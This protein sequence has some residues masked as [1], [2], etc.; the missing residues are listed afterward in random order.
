M[1]DLSLL[2]KKFASISGL[3]FKEGAGGLGLIEISTPICDAT[4]A[5]QGA[6]VLKW[7]PKG[8]APVIWLSTQSKFALGKSVRGGVPI[9]WP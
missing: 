2:S 9:C 7:A 6:Q 5:L 1:T 4:I 3:A 8:E